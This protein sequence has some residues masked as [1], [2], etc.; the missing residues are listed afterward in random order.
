M[1]GWSL[2]IRYLA[3]RF[4][5]GAAVVTI[6]ASL[7]GLVGMIVY[8]KRI[9]KFT[10]GLRPPQFLGIDEDAVLAN[11]TD[12]FGVGHNSGDTIST[13]IQAVLH[14]A[15]VVEIDVV[16]SDGVLYAGHNAPNRI[17]GQTSFQGPRLRDA[18]VVSSAAGAVQ[19]DLKI[20]SQA[21]IDLV[22]AF[23]ST[24]PAYTAIVLS[25][26]Y[27]DVLTALSERVPKAVLL[28]SVGS[29]SRYEALKNEPETIAQIDGVSIREDLVTEESADWLHEQ[30]LQIW[31]WAVNQP[32]RAAELA[33]LGIDGLTTDNLAILD[34][35][36]GGGPDNRQVKRQ[37]AAIE[38]AA[39]NDAETDTEDGGGQ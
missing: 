36:A 33:A 22:G 19:L 15:D 35:L 20:S 26:A 7:S 17:F 14:G 4:V 37:S 29:S 2:Q 32:T 24:R 5:I 34:A 11:H 16:L 13:S 25:S 27:P 6:V 8:D 18:W 12:I 28:L 30:N 21:Y 9:E 39:Q 10:I 3:H 31:A 38:Q 23:L 1:T